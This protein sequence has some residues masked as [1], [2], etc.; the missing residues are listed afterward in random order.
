MPERED[1]A[2]FV[3][4]LLKVFLEKDVDPLEMDGIDP[5]IDALMAEIEKELRRK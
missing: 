1:R 2:Y 4:G 5:E 3:R